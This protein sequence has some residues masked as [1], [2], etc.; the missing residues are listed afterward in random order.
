MFSLSQAKDDMEAY[1]KLTDQV[2]EQILHSSSPEMEGA[3]SLLQRI[4]TRD[5]YFFVGEAKKKDASEFTEEEI[6]GLKQKLAEHTNAEKDNFEVVQSKFDYGNGQKDPIENAFFYTKGD[7]KINRNKT[8]HVSMYLP[9]VFSE[10]FIR[11]YWKNK[12]DQRRYHKIQKAFRDWCK[13][14][15]FIATQHWLRLLA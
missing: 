14:K 12:K 7:H 15:G 5:L 11:V 10:N 9:S 6:K 1:T 8:E 2:M 13:K 3:R 4:L